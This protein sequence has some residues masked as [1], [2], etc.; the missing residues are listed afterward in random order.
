MAARDDN[1]AHRSSGVLSGQGVGIALAAIFVGVA[2][3]VAY[4]ASDG[5]LFAQPSSQSPAGTGQKQETANHTST[6]SSEAKVISKDALDKE[7]VNAVAKPPLQPQQERTNTAASDTKQEL[8][9]IK[10][11]PWS[12]VAGQY[13]KDSQA[14]FANLKQLQPPIPEKEP[15]VLPDSIPVNIEPKGK[16]STIDSDQSIFDALGDTTNP[17]E[18]PPIEDEEDDDKESTTQDQQNDNQE[19][20]DHEQQTDDQQNDADN[21][22]SDSGDS[23]SGE[24]P[25]EGSDDNSSSG[26][27]SNDDQSGE[28]DNEVPSTNSTDS[29]SSNSTESSPTS[30]NDD[31]SDDIG[32][33]LSLPLG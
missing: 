15:L 20:D 32:I 28:S 3:A 19:N 23:S 4:V 18:I 12:S 13:V 8:L 10:N 16:T 30:E 21:G 26:S 29:S 31:N 22:D 1:N 33:Q 25:S 11:F 5:A 7:P 27:T 9:A 2:L 24:E 6:T 14:R 17:I